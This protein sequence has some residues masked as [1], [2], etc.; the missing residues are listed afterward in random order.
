MRLLSLISAHS[1]TILFSYVTGVA[2]LHAFI[3]ELIDLVYTR[4]TERH[5]QLV[6]VVHV[7][8]DD[9]GCKSL[10]ESNRIKVKPKIKTNPRQM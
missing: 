3:D 9:S 1:K 5:H 7:H 4:H 8:V 6:D 10:A 2:R